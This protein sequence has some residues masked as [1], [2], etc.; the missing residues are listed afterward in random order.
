MLKYVFWLC[1]RMEENWGLAV[2]IGF[3]VFIGAVSAGFFFSQTG[4]VPETIFSFD[5]SAFVERLT[6]VSFA[7]FLASLAFVF[8]C[9]AAGIGLLEKRSLQQ[10]VLAG[11]GVGLIVSML[12]FNLLSFF[13]CAL[14]V[15]IALFAGIE[16][17]F[18]KSE[19]FK[20][21]KTLQLGWHVAGKAGFVTG[22]GILVWGILTL[23]PAQLAFGQSFED[24]IFDQAFE[25]AQGN[26]IKEQLQDSMVDNYVQAQTQIL[27][28]LAAS[29]AFKELKQSSDPAS[30][31]FVQTLGDAQTAVSSDAYR[32]QLE[33]SVLAQEALPSETRA[34]TESLIAQQFPW[35]ESMQKWIWL[36]FAFTMASIFW[37][38]SSLVLRPLGAAFGF[39]LGYLLQIVSNA[40]QNRASAPIPKV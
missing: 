35:M 14:F 6:T 33:Q 21:F 18:S 26:G 23:Y 9:A 16:T 39:V 27:D 13:V 29:S 1:F 36:I 17:G 3:L 24:S 31:N 19:Q 40:M 22:I 10:A 34:A 25:S 32:Y 8:G 4:L 20:S 15:G 28:Q 5:F 30:A 2:A 38:I 7:G 11:F 37:M 12:L